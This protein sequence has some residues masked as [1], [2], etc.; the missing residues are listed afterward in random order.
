MSGGRGEAE[1]TGGEGAGK[2]EGGRKGKRKER[3]E[4]KEV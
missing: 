4:L 1:R 3:S 2:G